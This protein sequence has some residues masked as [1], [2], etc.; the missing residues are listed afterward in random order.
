MRVHL[1]TLVPAVAL[2]HLVNGGA[3]QQQQLVIPLASVT[4]DSRPYRGHGGLSAG[5]SS[6]LLIDY[7]EPQRSEILDVL[8]LPGH[9]AA[10]D[11]LKIE[12][13]GDDQSTDG[14]EPAHSHSVGDL[15]CNR[16]YE[17]WLVEEARK[18]NPAVATYALP[19]GFP[20]P[21]DTD[22]ATN[23]TNT[24]ASPT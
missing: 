4:V 22:S 24:P 6:R 10:L 1:R 3:Q 14:V 23:E 12:I 20:Y 19:W 15:G 7:P 16:G 21:Y 11:M 2:L 9:G 13:G 17:W 8:F 5:A 18:R